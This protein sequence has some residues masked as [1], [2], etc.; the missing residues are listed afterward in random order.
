MN[1]ANPLATILSAGMMLDWLGERH[2]DASCSNAAVVLEQAVEMVLREGGVRTP[3]IGGNSTT[4]EVAEAV[5][6]AVSSD[7]GSP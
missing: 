7:Q 2:S 1:G 4:I 5:A 6:R 3:D